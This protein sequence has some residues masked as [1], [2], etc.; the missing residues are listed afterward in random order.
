MK[1]LKVALETQFAVGMATG[2]GVYAKSLAAALRARDDVDVVELSDPRFDVWR[3]DRRVWWDQVRAP[4]LARRS[5]ADVVHFTGGTLP[6]RARR[7]AVLTLHD[8]VWLRGANR[9]RFYTR[10]YFGALQKQLARGADALVVDTECARSD[11]A[12]GIGVEAG[13][14]FVAG[15]GID[16]AFLGLT[17][18]PADRPFVLCVG[19]VEERKDL[20]TAVMA[21]RRIEG[22]ALVSVGPL[23]PYADK[24]RAA[25]RACGVDDRVELRG[26]VDQAVLYDLYARAALL[27]FPSRYEGFGLPVLQALGC[28]LPV[29]AA[30]N[31]VVEEVAGDCA[32]YAPLGDAAALAKAFEAI[33]RGGDAVNVR[34]A[35]GRDR[36]KGFTWASV[37]RRMVDVYRSV[38]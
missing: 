33:L 10:W 5:G 13:R 37:A 27:A 22:L 35:R 11:V 28:G 31:P 17:R 6:L 14:I 8:L 1:R 19:T 32:W 38:L 20:A 30:R 18:R 9:G 15:A 21:L 23:T 26:Y 7:P 4:A 12:E 2:L 25:A 36:A 16:E 34:T 29:A 24:V 3:F